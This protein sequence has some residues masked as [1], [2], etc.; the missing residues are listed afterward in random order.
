MNAADHLPASLREI[1][2]IDSIGVAGVLALIEAHSGRPL[3]VPTPERLHANHPLALV[4]GLDG[5]LDLARHCPGDRIDI[6]MGRDYKAALL[7]AEVD[8]ATGRGDSEATIA[9]RHGITTRWVR[10]LR[11]RQRE[12]DDSQGDLF[13]S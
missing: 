7:A 10:E 4:L 1:A 5:A 13:N 6:P 8:A 9:G 11:R 3:Y 2:A 12:A